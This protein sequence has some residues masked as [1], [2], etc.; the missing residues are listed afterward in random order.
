V[1]P[2]VP[3]VPLLNNLIQA[4][5]NIAAQM[6]AMTAAPK[7]TYNIDGENV[8]WTDHWNSLVQRSKE[9]NELIQIAG[10]QFELQTTM[11]PSGNGGIFGGFGGGG[12]WP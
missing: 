10:G 2:I 6:A 3:D 11:M 4:R 9:I 12:I 1:S 7:P 5:S 8:S